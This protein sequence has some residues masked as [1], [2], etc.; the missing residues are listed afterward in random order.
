MKIPVGLL[1]IISTIITFAC[2]E[3]NQKEKSIES[4]SISSDTAIDKNVVKVYVTNSGLI[5][6]DGKNISLNNLDTTLKNLKANN[7]IVYYSRDN[8]AEDPPKESMQ[9][10]EL[11]VKYS[12]PVK[13]YTDKTFT[14]I[15]EE[16]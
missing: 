13:L 2:N 10:M 15:I 5:T 16:N 4:S 6:A 7:G 12:L 9:V 8:A 14:Q 1:I 3:S 11:I